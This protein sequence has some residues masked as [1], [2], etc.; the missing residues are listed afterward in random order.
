MLM[1][2]SVVGE[3]VWGMCECSETVLSRAIDDEQLSA[4]RRLVRGSSVTSAG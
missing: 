2:W 4:R 1:W 3:L